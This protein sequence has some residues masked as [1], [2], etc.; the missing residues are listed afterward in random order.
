M[1]KFKLFAR[2]KLKTSTRAPSARYLRFASSS[3]SRIFFLRFERVCVW[4]CVCVQKNGKEKKTEKWKKELLE[5]AFGIEK[6][7]RQ[8]TAI[9]QMLT[10]C[11]VNTDQ[12][13]TLGI[14]IIAKRNVDFCSNVLDIVSTDIVQSRSKRNPLWIYTS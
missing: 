8:Y 3:I 6:I 7:F 5:A 11:W 1:C 10:E 4:V 12:I 14:R 9:K 13:L 2:V